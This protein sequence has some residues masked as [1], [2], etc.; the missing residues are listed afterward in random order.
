MAAGASKATEVLR[1][2][3]LVIGGGGAGAHTALEATARGAR[4]QMVVKGLL[5]KSGCSIFAGYFPYPDVTTPEK[6]HE[7]LV[8]SVRYYN[9]YL[10]D[11]DYVMRMEAYMRDE[12][13]A[14]LERLGVY[15]RRRDDGA[16]EVSPNRARVVVAQKQGA[17][18]TIIMDKL[19]R[20]IL[21]QGIPVREECAATGLLVDDGRVVGATVLDYRHGE[22]FVVLAKATVIATGHSDFLAR[23]AT[24]TREQSADGIAMAL[25]AGAELA[26]LEIQWWHVSDMAEPRAWMRL[27]ITPSGLLGTEET[28]RLYNTNGEMFYEQAVHSPTSTIPYVEQLRRL[29]L[30]VEAGAAR[31]DGGYYSGYEHIPP[32]V[33][34]SGQQHAKVWAKLG[35][36]LGEDRLEGAISWH[37]RQG[38]IDLEPETMRTRV[39]G[40]YAAGAI[41]GHYLGGLAP[42]SYD[43]RVAGAASAEDAAARP[44]PAPPEGAIAAEQER[45]LGF[46]RTAAEGPRPTELKTRVR[47]IMWELGY[48]KNEAKLRAALAALETVREEGLPRLRL[49]RAARTWNT[50]WLDALDLCSMLD[51]CEAAVR[52]G[53][54]R[55]ESRGPFFRDDYPYVDNAN[56]LRKVLISRADGE[57]GSRTEPYDLPYVR[58]EADREPFFEVDY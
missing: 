44:A 34:E 46:L 54:V 31:W 49:E 36:E 26:N 12:F 6:S 37:M 41:G 58:P 5:G 19:R 3:V 27:H 32:D 20:R 55:T 52:S 30:Q 22:L 56:W 18:G 11:Q 33:I 45:V 4:V 42:A 14:E 24:A 57:W 40:L 35:L 38:G 28:S 16:L 10:T 39:P 17:S 15:W 7:R 25:G 13:F 51:A 53:L 43:G 9:H 23:R 47:E 29:S 1:T 2:D 48:V 8:N 50:D 21:S